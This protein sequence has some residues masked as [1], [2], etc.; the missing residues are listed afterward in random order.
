MKIFLKLIIFGCLISASASAY[1]SG[2]SSTRLPEV[3]VTDHSQSASS[4]VP[5]AEEARAELEKI[6]GGVYLVEKE[7]INRGRASTPQDL[8]GWVPGL[9]VQQRDTASLESRI[10]IRG[11]GLQRTFH[12]RGINLLQDGI[13][14]NQADGS[15]DAQRFDPLTVD[16]TEVYRGGNALRYGS[17][18][19][20]GAVNFVSPTGYTADPFQARLEFGS[21]DYIRS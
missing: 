6:P 8:L 3:V 13:P 7:D 14:L 18:T 10:S 9:H 15:G 2:E 12:L 11:S 4:V 1:S 5:E 17:S 20:G 16:Y 19:L 21:F